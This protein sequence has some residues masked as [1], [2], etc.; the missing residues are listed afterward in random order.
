M[1]SVTLHGV[2][3]SIRSDEQILSKDFCG[4]LLEIVS[5]FYF[6]TL[7]QTFLSDTVLRVYKSIK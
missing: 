4:Q 5:K 2:G 6:K 1:K 3:V 7:N